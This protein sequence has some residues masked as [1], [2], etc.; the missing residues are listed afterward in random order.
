MEGVELPE[1]DSFPP[2]NQKDYQ[3]FMDNLSPFL[4]VG[5]FPSG[6][7]EIPVSKT[8]NPSHVFEIITLTYPNLIDKY[9]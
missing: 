3:V 2:G 4:G 9:C 8:K 6:E 7:V 1:E 5:N